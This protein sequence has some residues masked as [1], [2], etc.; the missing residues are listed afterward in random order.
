MTTDNTGVIPAVAPTDAATPPEPSQEEKLAALIEQKVTSA[1]AQ[2]TEM[3]KRE[4]Q[5]VKDRSRAEVEAAVR[6]AKLAENV[7]SVTR[8][9][10]QELDPDLAKELELSELRAKEASRATLEQ[11]SA[12][13]QQQE[14]FATALRNSLLAHLA[15][16]GIDPEDK[17]IDWAKDT[18]NYVE[19]RSRFDA[20]VAKVLKEEKQTM[21]SSLEKRLKDLEAKISQ[22]STEANSVSTTTSPGVVVGS[23]KDFTKK[24]A[25]GELPLTKANIERY[26]K[27]IAS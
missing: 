14:T 17:R 4:I 7:L 18:A 10:S 8:Q 27:L 16:L 20:S 23:D 13:R 6:R 12:Q 26:N 2:A 25:S 11:E 24:F 5:S 15:A 19:G 22:A 1:I 3:A 21:Q 9:R